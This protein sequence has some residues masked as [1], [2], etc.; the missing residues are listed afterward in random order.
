MNIE[1]KLSKEEMGQIVTNRYFSK[2][3]FGILCQRFKMKKCDIGF[4]GTFH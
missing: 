2:I 1:H 3:L 4:G